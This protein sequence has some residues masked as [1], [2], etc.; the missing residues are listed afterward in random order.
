MINLLEL[1]VQIFGL[2]LRKVK[3]RLSSLGLDH[4]SVIFALW[5]ATELDSPMHRYFIVQLMVLGIQH[6]NERLCFFLNGVVARLLVLQLNALDN[7][8]RAWTISEDFFP[9]LLFLK[10]AAAA[11][12]HL[13]RLRKSDIAF[14]QFDRVTRL[15]QEL[16][17]LNID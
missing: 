8:T 4:L 17:L 16:T 6:C 13:Q 9:F 12:G 1:S 7:G 11:L 15:T 14:K 3:A 2:D 10:R 5:R